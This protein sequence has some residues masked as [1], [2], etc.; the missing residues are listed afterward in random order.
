MNKTRRAH[1]AYALPRHLRRRDLN[2]GV[3]NGPHFSIDKGGG[4]QWPCPR[5][6]S[7]RGLQAPFPSKIP[8]RTGSLTIS[9]EWPYSLFSGNGRGSLSLCV[10]KLVS[11]RKG[12]NIFNRR[13]HDLNDSNLSVTT[14]KRKRFFSQCTRLR[15]N[16]NFLVPWHTQLLQVNWENVND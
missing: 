10:F 14:K 7:T 6:L 9:R 1:I 5:D 13:E 11:R 15:L 3:M 8:Q 4:D 16:C 2:W 12:C